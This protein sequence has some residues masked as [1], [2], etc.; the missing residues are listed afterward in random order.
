VMGIAALEVGV[1]RLIGVLVPGAAWLAE[2]VPSPPV[3]QILSDYLPT[4][5][6]HESVGGYVISP[7]TEILSV[8]K[9]AVFASN[10]TVHRGQ[11]ELRQSF[12]AEVLGAI[13]DVLWMCD[14]FTGQKWA[15]PNLSDRMR[16]AL[17]MLEAAD[18]PGTAEAAETASSTPGTADTTPRA[19]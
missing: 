6:A 3:V 17:P 11:G 16:A 1:K 5:P 19:E 7:P 8:L 13:A 15:L 14:Y 12:I 9:N 4:I 10:A 18:S 2:N